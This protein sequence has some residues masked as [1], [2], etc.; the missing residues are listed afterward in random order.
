L[1]FLSTLATE[2][3]LVTYS[4]TISRKNTFSTTQFNQLPHPTETMS[5]LPHKRKQPELEEDFELL[6]V[7]GGV[8]TTTAQE[9][10]N[11]IDADD[12]GSAQEFD[13]CPKKRARINGTD[14][15]TADFPEANSSDKSVTASKLRP[16]E[17][18]Q[19]PGEMRNQIYELIIADVW[20]EY[21]G[22]KYRI[23]Q[24]PRSNSNDIDKPM[25][26][27]GYRSISQTCQQL[28]S[29]FGLIINCLERTVVRLP[30]F[31]AFIYD[32][33]HSSDRSHRSHLAKPHRQLPGR[34][35]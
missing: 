7:A 15:E 35:H 3:Y 10:S 26:F 25:K 14:D 21:S 1:S 29:E 20:Q 23:M 31:M 33:H 6:S 5:P 4:T 19:L 12:S 2:I 11:M 30:D 24:D 28:R 13:A 16:F 17:F 34:N 18:L 22:P 8:L 32:C 27:E 9:D